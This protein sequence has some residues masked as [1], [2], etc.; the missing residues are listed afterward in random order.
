MPYVTSAD[1]LTHSGVP[2]PTSDDIAWAEDVA[3]A[4]EGLIA[5]RMEGVTVDADSPAEAEL[6]VAALS[7]AAA[8]YTRR[9][10][11]HGILSIGPD[12]QAVRLGADIAIALK[13]VF[14]RYATPGIG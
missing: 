1:V 13:P 4:I 6:R 7:D 11:P 10:A 14:G 2:D 3:A 5:T 8:A 12:G 9:R